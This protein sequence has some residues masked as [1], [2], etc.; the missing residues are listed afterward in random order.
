MLVFFLSPTHNQVIFPL[1]NVLD[2]VLQIKENHRNEHSVGFTLHTAQHRWWRHSHSTPLCLPGSWVTLCTVAMRYSLPA[3]ESVRSYL[4]S[5]IYG[6]SI[7]IAHIFQ[8]PSFHFI[9]AP[10]LSSSGICKVQMPEV[11]KCFLKRQN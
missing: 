7:T 5:Q 8:Y 9:K 3:Q 11:T 6:Y 1:S 10:K 4:S 2:P